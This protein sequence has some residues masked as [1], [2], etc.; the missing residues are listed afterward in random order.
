MDFWTSCL[1]STQHIEVTIPESYK[2]KAGD[3][4][5]VMAANSEELV[6]AYLDALKIPHDAVYKLSLHGEEPSRSFILLEQ[7][8]GGAHALLRFVED[9]ALY[10]EINYEHCPIMLLM[11]QKKTVSLNSRCVTILSSLMGTK[12]K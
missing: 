12:H 3:H 5:G 10:L 7:P 8:I 2:Y 4:F 1:R 9:K 11:R 6:L